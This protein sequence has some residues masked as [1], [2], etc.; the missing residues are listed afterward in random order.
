VEVNTFLQDEVALIKKWI[1]NPHIFIVS[2]LL[3]L[4]KQSM[5]VISENI[6]AKS[7][8]VTPKIIKVWSTVFNVNNSSMSFALPIQKATEREITDYVQPA[9]PTS[10]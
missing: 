10:P 5:F 3:D 7:V 8:K 4:I 9:L 2:N 6:D 1:I